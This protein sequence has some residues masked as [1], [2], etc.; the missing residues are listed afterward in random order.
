MALRFEAEGRV[1]AV[2]E[3]GCFV[4]ARGKEL[5]VYDGTARC[6]VLAPGRF[7]HVGIG[8]SAEHVAIGAGD[9]LELWSGR[10]AVKSW[11]VGS[12]QHWGA[13]R[14][15]G[16]QLITHH[17]GAICAWD[18]ASGQARHVVEDARITIAR[19]SFALD[20]DAIAVRCATNAPCV[21]NASLIAISLSRGVTGLLRPHFD[22]SVGAV[23]LD[24]GLLTAGCH[25]LRLDE[26]TRRLELPFEGFK[27]EVL[28]RGTR[29]LV[30]GGRDGAVRAWSSI[31]NRMT[32]FETGRTYAIVHVRD[33]ADAIHAIDSQG[34]VFAWPAPAETDGTEQLFHIV[35]PD[36]DAWQAAIVLAAEHRLDDAVRRLD[37]ADARPKYRMARAFFES[38]IAR[39][40]PDAFRARCERAGLAPGTKLTSI[41]T[42]L[43]KAEVTYLALGAYMSWLDAPDPSPTDQQLALGGAIARSLG[44]LDDHE[45]RSALLDRMPKP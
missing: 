29:R 42:D 1:V 14:F 3:D 2:A 9:R 34:G 28:R 13:P 36:E 21:E 15:A 25:E 38:V 20:G 27:L 5:E 32:A 39:D 23:S 31:S 16:D 37:L 17:R 7:D 18:V 40:V 10:S 43:L 19:R 6:S 24:P 22:G 35:P 45:M 26:G 41:A 33:D 44:A 4:V 8:P 11:S 30:L 12:P